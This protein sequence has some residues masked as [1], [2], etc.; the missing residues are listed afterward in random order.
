MRKLS[1]IIATAF[2]AL[3]A[4]ANAATLGDAFQLTDNI[5]VA[6]KQR[7]PEGKSGDM[8]SLTA[9][10]KCQSID[11]VVGVFGIKLAQ[12]VQRLMDE[13]INDLKGGKDIKTCKATNDN[14]KAVVLTGSDEQAYLDLKARYEAL[15]RDY[16]VLRR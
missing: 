12:L 11:M 9:A 10:L 6:T 14:Y 2:F 7:C 16:P 3:S 13:C 1:L 5:K 4:T 8:A 15:L